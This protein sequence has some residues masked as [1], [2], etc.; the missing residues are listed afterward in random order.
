LLSIGGSD[1]KSQLQDAPDSQR[2]TDSKNGNPA[3]QDRDLVINLN[4]QETAL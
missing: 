2:K 1:K 4:G 3:D